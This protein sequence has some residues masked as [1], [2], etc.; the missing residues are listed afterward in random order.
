[1]PKQKKYPVYFVLCLWLLASHSFGLAESPVGDEKRTL[2]EQELLQLTQ[3]ADQGDAVAQ[4]K[5]GEMYQY[6][7]GVD[8][9]LYEAMILFRMAAE[10][11]YAPAQHNLG[12]VHESGYG[13]GKDQQEAVKWYRKA[14]LL[15]YVR[16]QAS[17]AL[18]YSNGKGVLRDMAMAAK[19]YQM[20]ADRGDFYSQAALARIYTYGE[21]V[22]VDVVEAYKWVLLAEKN[23]TY[24]V[25][26]TDIKNH[27]ISKMTTAQIAEAQSL[28]D[29]FLV[30]EKSE[31]PNSLLNPEAISAGKS[32]RNDRQDNDL[33]KTS[34]LPPDNSTTE[35]LQGQCQTF[36]T[37]NHPKAKGINFT[38]TYPESWSAREDQRPDII[39]TFVSENGSGMET[40]LIQTADIPLPAETVV[41]TDVI[42]D[43]LAPS[44]LRNMMPPEAKYLH[45][46][47][48]KVDS[49]PAGI[50]EFTMQHE[51]SGQI[52]SMHAWT[53]IFI[54]D[55][56]LVRLQ[57]QVEAP[58]KD[59]ETIANKMARSKPLF[60][61]MANRI[62]FPEKTVAPAENH[63][64]SKTSSLSS[65]LHDHR[66]NRLTK[67]IIIIVVPLM[68]AL[69]AA[70]ALRYLLIRRPLTRKTGLILFCFSLALAV[71]AVKLGYL[72]SEKQKEQAP[73]E[74][75]SPALQNVAQKQLVNYS[76]AAEPLNSNTTPETTGKENESPQ[77]EIDYFALHECNNWIIKNKHALVT[78]YDRLWLNSDWQNIFAPGALLNK[79][80]LNASIKNLKYL[81]TQINQF[82]KD[83]ES[84]ETKAVS[85]IE[86]SDISP[87]LKKLWLKDF[88]E[89]RKKRKIISDQLINVKS[90]LINQAG[91]LLKFMH[92][93]IDEVKYEN[94]SYVFENNL[95][96]KHFDERISEIGELAEKESSLSRRLISHN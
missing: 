69:I 81:R 7:R 91:L 73:P 4:N 29:H 84:L 1:M 74:S 17:L 46:Q 67:L 58:E 87:E 79:D 92:E 90:H 44:A 78:K 2:S 23:K 39:Q 14:A 82:Q 41:T 61:L 25:D 62:K 28:A 10:Q 95:D 52:Y 51:K 54:A 86:E 34:P 19:W 30:Q 37:K 77:K 3:S 68:I 88:N 47:R 12:W 22:R 65:L 66:F 18:M 48:A 24:R 72:D 70:L 43:L 96:K 60:A 31:S 8:K 59:K 63:A 36:N 85:K 57:F 9:N 75:T 5:L 71:T 94:N 38:I 16:S 6:G 26:E 32:S 53:L 21:G 13:I 50:L 40:A 83:L 49:K 33:S 76:Q 64:R 56:H 93:K 11:G 20:A 27:L 55:D 80:T 45:A 35:F 42:N 15:G 89:A